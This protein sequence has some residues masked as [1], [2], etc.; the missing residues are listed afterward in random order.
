MDGWMDG[1]VGPGV[2][3][4]GRWPFFQPTQRKQTALERVVCISERLL[5]H[6]LHTYSTNKLAFILILQLKLQVC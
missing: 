2:G 6:Y 4:V 1:A 5:S 3:Q